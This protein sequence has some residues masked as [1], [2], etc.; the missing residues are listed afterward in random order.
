MVGPRWDIWVKR[1]MR[2]KKVYPTQMK[3]GGAYLFYYEPDPEKDRNHNATDM[4]PLAIITRVRGAGFLAINLVSV[5]SRVRQRR[6]VAMFMD[7]VAEPRPKE[8]VRKILSLERFIRA[9]AIT[10]YA[11]KFYSKNRIEG[12][13]VEVTP[14]EMQELIDKRILTHAG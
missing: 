12:R 14:T 1:K 2:E 11:F 9:N 6:L 5:P 7:A 10:A 13:I 4:L 8:R 3:W